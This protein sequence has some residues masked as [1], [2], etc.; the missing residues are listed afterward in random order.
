MTCFHGVADSYI[1][2][3]YERDRRI[4]TPDFLDTIAE[5]VPNWA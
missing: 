3:G 4:V 1:N 5:H 2:T